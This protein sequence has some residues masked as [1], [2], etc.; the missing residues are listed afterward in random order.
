MGKHKDVTDFT[1]GLFVT[2]GQLSQNIF[3]TAGLVF[4]ECSSFVSTKSG[5]RKDEGYGHPRLTDVHGE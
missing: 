3:K 2:S 4:Q 5:I 1:K